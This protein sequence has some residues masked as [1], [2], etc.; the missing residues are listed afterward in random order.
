ML[1]FFTAQSKTVSESCSVVC[2]VDIVHK[3]KRGM[4]C[5]A[6]EQTLEPG[7]LLCVTSTLTGAAS[8]DFP[9]QRKG[10]EV[11]RNLSLS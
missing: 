4:Y 7:Q 1:S 10:G 3:C 6:S 11:S 8:F 2:A 5:P 9:N